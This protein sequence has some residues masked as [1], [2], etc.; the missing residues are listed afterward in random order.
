MVGKV[1]DANIPSPACDTPR[2]R[3]VPG[4]QDPARR[5]VQEPKIIVGGQPLRERDG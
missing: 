2:R 5:H 1:E 3:P 4:N